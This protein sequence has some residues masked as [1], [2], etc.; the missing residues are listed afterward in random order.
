V[1]IYLTAGALSQGYKDAQ[2]GFY[3]PHCR[4]FLRFS[5]VLTDER[6]AKALISL[7]APALSMIMRPMLF[8]KRYKLFFISKFATGLMTIL[9]T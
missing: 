7:M 9:P 5:L 4:S 2:H 3:Q 1:T 8:V 6:W